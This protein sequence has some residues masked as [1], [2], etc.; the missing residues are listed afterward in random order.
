VYKHQVGYFVSIYELAEMGAVNYIAS[1]PTDLPDVIRVDT[2]RHQLA[3]PRAFFL[4]VDATIEVLRYFCQ[5][6]RRH[7]A[8]RWVRY[9]DLGFEL[10]ADD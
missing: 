4:P 9:E 8:H 2:P 10:Y 7:P 6:G 3:I 1:G 5:T